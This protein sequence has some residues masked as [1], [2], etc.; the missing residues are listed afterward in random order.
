MDWDPHK[1]LGPRWVETPDIVADIKKFVDPGFDGDHHRNVSN[2]NIKKLSVLCERLELIYHLETVAKDMRA[3]KASSSK[4]EPIGGGLIKGTEV[5]SI[6][7]CGHD[8]AGFDFDIEA[9]VLYLLLT[10]IDT[11]KG[12]DPYVDAFD[13]LKG[14]NLSTGSQNW[15]ELKEEYRSQHGPTQLFKE[16]FLKDLDEDIKDELTGNLACVKVGD[17]RITED[18]SR[19]WERRDDQRRI[20]KIADE[21]YRI[22]STFTHS[23][24]R[25]FSLALSVSGSRPSG[26]GPV[27]V[28]R[29]GGPSLEDLLKKVIRC[30]AMKLLIK[31]QTG[32]QAREVEE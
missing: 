12:P 29:R 30:I 9:L 8:F 18:S 4:A 22:R 13:W 25:M 26:K 1:W 21:L 3:R 31:Q 19:A 15:D 24:L 28:R 16:A 2:G 32:R 14:R 23:S 20:R 6:N 5:D 17:R 7:I 27:L 10:C 11:I